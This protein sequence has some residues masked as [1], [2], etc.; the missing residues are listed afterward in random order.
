M[1][2]RWFITGQDHPLS[3]VITHIIRVSVFT[4]IHIRGITNIGLTPIT[5]AITDDTTVIGISLGDIP[6]LTNHFS[7]P[8][9]LDLMK[10]TRKTKHA[11]KKKNPPRR[12]TISPF[13]TLEAMKKAADTMNRTHPQ[14]WNF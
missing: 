8:A 7:H 5:R 2:T 12:P 6:G 3:I 1:K 4:I 13:L 14:S 11:T 10:G 9:H